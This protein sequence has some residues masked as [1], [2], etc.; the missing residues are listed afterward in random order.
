MI[1]VSCARMGPTPSLESTRPA[2]PT[3]QNRQVR[4]ALFVYYFNLFI[5]HLAGEAVDCHMHPVML[6]GFNNGI[7]V[8]AGCI[9]FEGTRL[10]HHVDQHIPIRV[11]ETEEMAG[12]TTSL[13]ALTV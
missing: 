3:R 12:G 10:S 13:R 2:P 4:W 6:L 9:W 8:Q 1:A 5:D 11:W 7:V